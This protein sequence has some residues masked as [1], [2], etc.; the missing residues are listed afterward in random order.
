MR[1]SLATAKSDS[2][3]VWKK[4]KG[5]C[6]ESQQES[7]KK[8]NELKGRKDK[9][10]RDL[11]SI[12]TRLAE[13]NSKL[14]E[15][16]AKSTPAKGGPSKAIAM[17]EILE[18]NVANHIA[19]SGNPMI[20]PAAID[21]LATAVSATPPGLFNVASKTI[22]SLIE[23]TGSVD[24]DEEIYCPEN[25]CQRSK[26][27]DPGFHGPRSAYVEC[28]RKDTKDVRLPTVWTAKKGAKKRTALLN[29]GM[30]R[31]VCSVDGTGGKSPKQK[32]Y[33]L[34]KRLRNALSGSSPTAS[35][36][37]VM[38]ELDNQQKGSK[39]AAKQAAIAAKADDAR[40]ELVRLEAVVDGL[41]SDEAAAEASEQNY[42]VL[43]GQERKFKL[44]LLRACEEKGKRQADEQGARKAQVN[45]VDLAVALVKKNML[46][47]KHFLKGGNP[48]T[49]AEQARLNDESEM[50]LDPDMAAAKAL[51]EAKK[52]QR[53]SAISKG[54]KSIGALG[55]DP[56]LV[57]LQ[58]LSV[59]K[60]CVPGKEIWCGTKRA[61]IDTSEECPKAPVIMKDEQGN[62]VVSQGQQA[63]FVFEDPL[64]K[65]REDDELEVIREKSFDDQTE[66]RKAEK[67]RGVAQKVRRENQ[68][69]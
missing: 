17:L 15:A 36:S 21:A 40:A 32:V 44:D 6:E 11:Q 67:A 51:A 28:F 47:L 8:I 64:D 19:K 69:H 4:V 60:G 37:V 5:T 24:D 35:A 53:D 2:K 63:A 65:A 55:V 29:S 66:S 46:L 3:N 52:K 7:D 9:A 61:C 49:T 13:A 22:S 16:R 43:L 39:D 25:F 56:S 18:H 59:K 38:K 48:M 58:M 31:Q 57:K 42:H 23:I 41:M 10:N 1:R 20:K 30:H 14:A 50:M 68:A 45:A 12:R 26:K 27:R 33:G 62:Q 54:I 34:L